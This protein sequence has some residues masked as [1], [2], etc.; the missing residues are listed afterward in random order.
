VGEG[1]ALAVLVAHAA[2]HLAGRRVRPQVLAAHALDAIG[3]AREQ[4]VG[5][6]H[7]LHHV[8]RRPPPPRAPR[9]A[10]PQQLG[11]DR[12]L[13]VVQQTARTLE[14]LAPVGRRRVRGIDVR[15][16]A[17]RG[18]DHEVH[19]GAVDA[20]HAGQGEDAPAPVAGRD[21]VLEQ[22]AVAKAAATLQGRHRLAAAD[23]V[24]LHPIPTPS[25]SDRDPI[26]TRRRRKASPSP[27]CLSRRRE[28]YPSPPR[29][30]PRGA[31]APRGG[32]WARCSRCSC[33]RPAA[34]P[35]P[36]TRWRVCA[37]ICRAGPASRSSCSPST[38]CARTCSAPTATRGPPRRTSTAS[39]RRRWSS[40]RPTPRRR[41]RRPPSPPPGPVCWPP[42]SST[43]GSWSRPTRWRRPSRTA[44]TARPPSS[45]TSR[46]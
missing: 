39:P 12:P 19:G 8:E 20:A 41:Y 26:A 46:S 28:V 25:R 30:G 5:R 7:L 40:S 16:L 35:A 2:P 11:G 4:L 10:H 33:W 24:E 1:E 44:A 32:R 6:R 34:A 31:H 42:G 29:R 27:G 23:A 22:I 45:T 21:V 9:L 37:S 38:R 43:A 14:R 15:K 13:P 3:V 36:T 17:D 18:I